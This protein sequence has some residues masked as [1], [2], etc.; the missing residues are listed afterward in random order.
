M[1]FI[2]TIAYIEFG[3]KRR[4]F[5]NWLDTYSDIQKLG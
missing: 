4:V 2:D 5:Q 3:N 1:S